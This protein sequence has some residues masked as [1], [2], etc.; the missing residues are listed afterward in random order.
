MGL[1]E[2]SFRKSLH[3]IRMIRPIA[4]L[5]KL[6]TEDNTH[7]TMKISLSAAFILVLTA[8]PSADAGAYPIGRGCDGRESG[9]T[10]N[11]HCK[12]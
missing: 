5:K 3:R 9:E 4:T 12:F 8:A 6:K 11:C 7:F 10:W 1:V 2:T